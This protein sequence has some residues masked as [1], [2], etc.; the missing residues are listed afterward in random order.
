MS[1]SNTYPVW[2]VNR[3][4]DGWALVVRWAVRPGARKGLQIDGGNVVKHPDAVVIHVCHVQQTS[5]IA[6][7]LHGI[8]QFGHT[9]CEI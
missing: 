3:G 2:F 4:R 9:H 6:P 7:Y 1:Y 5:A 8:V